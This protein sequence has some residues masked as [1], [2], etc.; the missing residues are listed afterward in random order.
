[1]SKLS[2]N[3]GVVTVLLERLEKQRLPRLLSLEEKV[4]RGELLNDS[5]LKFME[6]VTAD[7]QRI[8]PIIDKE[9][10]YQLLFVKLTNLYDDISARALENEK[11]SI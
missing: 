10:E 9:P 7:A 1:M 8:E 3:L 5:D 6:E 4:N 2:E 11:A